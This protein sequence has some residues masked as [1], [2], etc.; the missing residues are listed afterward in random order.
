MKK[1]FVK[2]MSLLCVLSII[3][4]VIVFA[5]AVPVYA[6]PRLEDNPSVFGWEDDKDGA[7]AYMDGSYDIR[8]GKNLRIRFGIYN[9]PPT[10]KW[11]L[12]DDYLPMLTTEFERD[13]C[14]VK[15][16]NFG[17]KVVVNGNDYVVAYSRVSI[18]NNGDKEVILDPKASLELIKLTNNSTRVKPGETVNHDYMIAMDKFGKNYDWPTD[19]ELKAVAPDFDTAHTQMVD[20]WN[21]RIANTAHFTELPDEK[22]MK[23]M[24][25]TLIQLCIINDDGLYAIGE[26]GYDGGGSWKGDQLEMIVFNI[27]NRN[28]HKLHENM[29]DNKWYQWNEDSVWWKMGYMWAW[30][31]QKTGD[32]EFVVENFIKPTTSSDGRNYADLEKL[33]DFI[34]STRDPVTGIMIP[35]NID[36]QGNWTMGDW[37]ALIGLSGIKYICD[38]IGQRETDPDKKAQYE[39]WSQRAADTYAD[40]YECDLRMM[41]STM[42]REEIDY[43]PTAINQSNEQNRTRNPVD[44]NWANH[45][46]CGRW[47]YEGYLFDAYQGP[48]EVDGEIL[49]PVMLNVDRSFDYG[50]GRLVGRLPSYAA[51]GFPGYFAAYN[52]SY[53]SGA[54]RGDRYRSFSVYAYQMMLNN[55][56]SPNGWWETVLYPGATV[57]EPGVHP[58]G[59]VG[60]CP[61]MW[62]NTSTAYALQ[63]GFV[64]EKIT[65][66]PA[67]RDLIIGRGTPRE[68]I[69]EGKVS[70]FVNYPLA[71]L[72]KVDI[73]LEGLADNKFKLTLTGDAPTGN[74]SLELAA[75]LNDSVK[76]VVADDVI[77]DLSKVYDAENGKVVVPGTTKEVIVT[78]KDEFPY[79]NFKATEAGTYAR[80]KR[81][82]NGNFQDVIKATVDGIDV[83]TGFKNKD[84]VITFQ[85]YVEEAGSYDVT[86]NVINKSGQDK[87]MAVYVNSELTAI[88]KFD[89]TG[90]LDDKTIT[91]QLRQ[92]MN[93]ISFKNDFGDN[94]PAISFAGIDV[95]PSDNEVNGL[96]LAFKKVVT[97]NKTLSN[98]AY[99]TDGYVNENKVATTEGQYL[100]ID[101]GAEY[102]ISDIVGYFDADDELKALLSLSSDFSHSQEYSASDSGGFIKFNPEVRARYVRVFTDGANNW[103]E[104]EIYGTKAPP[105]LDP[106]TTNKAII[107]LEAEHADDLTTVDLIDCPEGGKAITNIESN[108]YVLFE[109]VNFGDGNDIFQAR[110][111]S[112]S[113]SGGTIEIRIDS[114]DG[115]LAGSLSV[116]NTGST[117]KYETIET[118][119]TGVKGN[120]D[121]YLKFTGGGSDESMFNVNWF[122][123]YSSGIRSVMVFAPHPD[124]DALATAG[125]IRRAVM[126]NVPIKVVSVTN[127]DDQSMQKGRNRIKELYEANTL[128]GVKPQD[129]IYLGYGDGV[130]YNM[131]SAP[132]SNTVFASSIGR[133]TTYAWPEEGL[134][135]YHELRTG[136]P[137]EHNRKSFM[138]DI[139][140]LITTYMP[141]DVYCPS[142]YDSHP[143]HK[144]T[145]KAVDEALG[146]T[147]DDNFGYKPTLHRTVIQVPFDL[148]GWPEREI[149]LDTPMRPFTMPN[150][151]EEHT[152]F[153]W[154]EREVVPVPEEMMKVPRDQNLK[155]QSIMKFTTAIQQDAQLWLSYVKSDEFFFPQYEFS[156]DET[157]LTN[158]ALGGN[159]TTNDSSP[160][161]L[162][163]VNDGRVGDYCDLNDGAKYV[164]IDFGKS[165][166]IT[167]VNIWHY[168]EDARTYHDVVIQLSN[169]PT[170]TTG[171][172]TVFNND[173]DNSLGLGAGTDNEYVETPNG[174]RIRFDA[175]NARY[176][177]VWSRGNTVNIYNHVVEIQA[178]TPDPDVQY[179]GESRAE[180]GILELI[181]KEQHDDVKASDFEAMISI[182][183]SDPVALNLKDFEYNSITKTASFTFDK[184]EQLEAD[185]NVVIKSSFRSKSFP[186]AAF[187]VPSKIISEDIN[188]ALGLIPTLDPP[189]KPADEWL[190][191]KATDGTIDEMPNPRPGT[192]PLGYVN[193]PEEGGFTWLTFDLGTSYYL[194]KVKMWHYWP[195]GRIYKD[196]LVQISDDPNFETGVTTVFNNDKDNSAGCGIGTDDEYSE[197]Y[198]GKTIIFEPVKGRY[199]RTSANGSNRN[200][201]SH[202]VEFEVYATNPPA[203]DRL[204]SD[205]FTID[206]GNI[207]GRV[208]TGVEE[209]TSLA[210]LI[211]GLG[212][213]PNDIKIRDS[214]GNIITDMTK[215]AGTGTVVELVDDSDEILDSATVVI[216]FD[217]NGDGITDHD[218][219]D[220][221]VKYF[222]KWVLSFSDYQ[223]EALDADSN[224]IIDG[225]DKILAARNFT[226]KR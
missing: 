218:D 165:Y 119:V 107:M 87:F 40:L 196:V 222:S 156:S 69:M 226:P 88:T 120:H 44:G 168:F 155:W 117:G 109:N 36:T 62:G 221:I 59:G 186:D 14:T 144:A 198:A 211:E 223:L 58:I 129:I 118:S 151:F 160:L 188:I 35:S 5:N 174:K 23:S 135:N 64:S 7:V 103:S 139:L 184:I 178:F 216:R 57:W 99:L 169:D 219:Y 125:I 45:F 78:L 47:T 195:D 176:L 93:N 27:E 37:N 183:G 190:L 170:F 51:G 214:S 6:A 67:K 102:M 220:Y 210:S 112:S 75:L 97:S 82:N 60:S 34:D 213:D 137:A 177:R 115:Q 84:S 70:N 29:L 113:N 92:G 101:L 207:A 209:S 133:T 189:C 3:I 76:E 166:D 11:Y 217:I 147:V 10:L 202:W 32:I 179:A 77:Q 89:P 66:D 122:K 116:P 96:N 43:I 80:E 83:Q 204:V 1:A 193:G 161:W 55:Q 63:Q 140:T 208:I 54:L 110:V 74:I 164:Q 128:L 8:A 191:D 114:I 145:Y 25:A 224:G 131:M 163:R 20:Y 91:L 127:G 212:N 136:E 199:I 41:I 205:T 2:R 124:D 30:Y 73:R 33:L 46:H 152:P 126:D 154:D 24:W 146:I 72:K 105:V 157:G 149:G 182:D 12:E 153:K 123:L 50:L 175:I 38:Y 90:S 173:R 65:V 49:P 19:E 134:Y 138:E 159:V 31:L 111:A 86:A 9:D 81:N 98:A 108:D 68:W 28:W 150:G 4:Q 79:T 15:I 16:Q 141:T 53:G 13:N 197:T 18:T 203:E 48:L 21:N 181:L 215:F 56:Q 26:N 130:L 22:I 142:I 52:G 167:K 61:H 172:H 71:D 187:K 106:S 158:V 17:N 143:D 171:V 200:R 180:N 104:I 206:Y 121:L 132:N 100:Q 192:D 39:E 225:V 94:Q 42:E 95:L 194:Y 201:N 162:S 85:V 185:Q 148:Y